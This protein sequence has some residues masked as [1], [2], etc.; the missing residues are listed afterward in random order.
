MI[1]CFCAPI[2]L[3]SI[4]VEEMMIVLFAPVVLGHSPLVP[5]SQHGLYNQN[6]Q[7][8]VQS[9]NVLMT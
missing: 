2:E 3:D 9:T 8:M 4:L 5:S 6:L 7:N 1:G